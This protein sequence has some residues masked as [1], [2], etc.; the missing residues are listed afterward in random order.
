MDRTSERNRRL[1][2]VN[3]KLRIKI[4]KL[5]RW[6]DELADA[7]QNYRVLLEYCKEL[8]ALVRELIQTYGIQLPDWAP[9]KS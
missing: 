7:D 1:R 6:L 8:E 9:L 2:R 3:R 4:R 5:K